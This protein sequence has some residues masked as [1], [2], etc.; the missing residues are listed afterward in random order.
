[1]ALSDNAKPAVPVIKINERQR[2]LEADANKDNWEW[3]E[4]PALDIFGTP[5]SG[6][7]INFESFHPEVDEETGKWTGKPGKY[8]VKP[9]VAGEIRRLLALKMKGDL[10]ILQPNQDLV[11]LDIMN[12]NGMRLGGKV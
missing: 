9:S 12:R 2:I 8:L 5:H 7:S 3:V 10:R 4:I 6:V 11:A 1:M